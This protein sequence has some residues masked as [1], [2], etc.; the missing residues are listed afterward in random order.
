MS[1]NSTATA[2]KAPTIDALTANLQSTNLSS[3]SFDPRAVSPAD[4]KKLLLEPV[5][6]TVAAIPAPIAPQADAGASD[7]AIKD[8]ETAIAPVAPQAEGLVRY[9]ADR[10]AYEGGEFVLRIGAPGPGD[11]E[12]VHYTDEEVSIAVANVVKASNRSL[13]IPMSP[14]LAPTMSITK[15]GRHPVIP[16]TVVF[17]YRS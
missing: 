12:T 17:R 8:A 16:N 1:T 15:S 11:L 3:S 6:E 13:D 2:K 10:V 4:L 5:D 14:A 7:A 9:I